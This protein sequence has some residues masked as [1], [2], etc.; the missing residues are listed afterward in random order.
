M[1]INYQL[2]RELSH[3]LEMYSN[4]IITGLKDAVE[5]NNMV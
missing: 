3:M 2:L 5:Q 4:N 1:D